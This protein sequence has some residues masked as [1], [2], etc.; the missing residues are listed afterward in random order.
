MLINQ[1]P[2]P[3]QTPI[4]FRDEAGS[5]EKDVLL[6]TSLDPTYLLEKFQN[7]VW[8]ATTKVIF[9]LGILQDSFTLKNK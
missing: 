9:F 5:T 8:N 6:K 1:S 2:A 7:N 3:S 4:S